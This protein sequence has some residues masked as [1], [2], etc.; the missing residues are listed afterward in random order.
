MVS[1][2]APALPGNTKTQAAFGINNGGMIV[3]QY[4]RTDTYDLQAK[5]RDPSGISP[6]KQRIVRRLGGAGR[7]DL[8][9]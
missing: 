9:R 3:G 4:T 6:S 5:L 1:P 2:L 8:L 7:F